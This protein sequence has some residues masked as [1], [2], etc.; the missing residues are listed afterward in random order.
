MKIKNFNYPGLIIHGEDDKIVP[1]A[2]SEYFYDHISSGDKAI[3]IYKGLYHEILNERRKN[4][5]IRDIVG[6]IEK[7]L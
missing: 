5:V 7:R 3:K 1:K 6:W 4:E 2:C